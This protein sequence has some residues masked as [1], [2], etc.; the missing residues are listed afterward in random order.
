M[1]Q[2]DFDKI[3]RSF[4]QF[5]TEKIHPTEMAQLTE[6]AEEV[7]PKPQK[8]KIRE[9]EKTTAFGSEDAEVGYKVSWTGK[10]GTPKSKL[11]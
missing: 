2:R 5:L 3:Q 11:Y 8:R 6:D 10:D 7:V 1:E 9:I 4:K